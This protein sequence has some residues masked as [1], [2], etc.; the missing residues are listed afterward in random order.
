MFVTIMLHYT[1]LTTCFTGVKKCLPSP[2]WGIVEICVFC[3]WN[4]FEALFFPIL[5][6][7]EKKRA[8]EGSSLLDEDIL[9]FIM[10][11]TVYR[12]KDPDCTDISGNNE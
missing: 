6:C 12:F 3:M 7:I 11:K 10:K 9:E 8:I 4:L 5:Y 2:L 1:K